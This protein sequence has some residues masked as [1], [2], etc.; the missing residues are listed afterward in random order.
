MHSELNTH[1]VLKNFGNYSFNTPRFI[2]FK[3]NVPVR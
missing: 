1:N 3:V 2:L